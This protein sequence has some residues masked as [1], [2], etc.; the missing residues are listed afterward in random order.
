MKLSQ[1]VSI[2]FLFTCL[3]N[4][5]TPKFNQMALKKSPKYWMVYVE[6][7]LDLT[8]AEYCC[9]K[10]DLSVCISTKHL[11]RKTSHLLIRSKLVTVSP[12]LTP[13]ESSCEARLVEEREHYLVYKDY[14]APNANWKK[15]APFETE[16]TVV[17]PVGIISRKD[18]AQERRFVATGKLF[19]GDC[20]FRVEHT[21]RLWL[22][23]NLRLNITFL[24]IQFSWGN[25][26]KCAIG[27]IVIK[28][29]RFCG[30]HPV[31]S[32]FTNKYKVHVILMAMP[33][34][35]YKTEF[36]F[37]VV[38]QSQI[39]SYSQHK[40]ISFHSPLLQLKGPTMVTYAHRIN[41]QQAVY[42]ITVE[43]HSYLKIGI[44]HFDAVNSEIFDGPGSQSKKLKS[45]QNEKHTHI[46]ITSA[47]S[48]F[49]KIW[50]LAGIFKY[51]SIQL[52]ASDIQNVTSPI[53]INSS[54][55]CFYQK[56]VC[57]VVLKANSDAHLNM[58]VV[59][60]MYHGTQHILCKFAGISI[61]DFAHK[62]TSKQ[63]F[64][65][66]SP[67]Q[68]NFSSNKNIYSSNNK[69]LVIFYSYTE[70]AISEYTLTTSTTE[71]VP[72]V[73]DVCGKISSIAKPRKINVVI[74]ASG[75]GN[76]KSV[77]VTTSVNQCTVVQF[78]FDL[79]MEV[80]HRNCYIGKFQ[81]AATQLRGRLLK[82]K[83]QGYF[84]TA[85]PGESHNDF[86]SKHLTKNTS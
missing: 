64:S 69:V 12:L 17:H 30:V 36:V 27:Q 13:P 23:P 66:C 49:A 44:T 47:F 72:V 37:S 20:F 59:N 18:F 9:Q 43:K 62:W 1:V 51:F 34:V 58:T 76:Y 6:K 78:D 32:I 33:S 25:F 86:K 38:D 5:D 31:F 21:W 35:A 50:S 60:M 40:T 29:F 70:Y 52:G 61:F 68:Q 67:A 56:V 14:G 84:P 22:D 39:T 57:A 15:S 77:I 45:K 71:C 19:Q 7:L 81:H 74:Q 83:W 28:E 26:H 3:V 75:A 16:D 42:H 8:L 63:L 48:C 65:F 24:V 73:I 79:S 53:S 80:F 2:P 10:K 85:L 41:I 54:M 46:Y 11:L 82:Y 4:S 55:S